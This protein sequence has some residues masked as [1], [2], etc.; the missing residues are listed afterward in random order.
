MRFSTYEHAPVATVCH[1]HVGSHHIRVCLGNDVFEWNS[2]EHGRATHW[3]AG[4]SSLRG[5][6][7]LGVPFPKGSGIA[8][9]KPVAPD[10]HLLGH[11]IDP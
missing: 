2:R 11:E 1:M 5:L 6:S 9:R 4:G 8:D 3:D 10:V 7:C